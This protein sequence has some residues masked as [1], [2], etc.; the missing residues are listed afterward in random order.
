M[1]L[2]PGIIL[3]STDFTTLSLPIANKGFLGLDSNDNHTKI[4]KNDGSIVDLEETGASINSPTFTGVPS[5]PT[6]SPGT[7][8]TQF[9]TT[10]FVLANIPAGFAIINITY[11]ALKALKDTSSLQEGYYRITDF[12]T[13]YDQP[14]FS[15]PGVIKIPSLLITK[16]SAVESI[17]VLAISSDQLSPYAYSESFPDDI[18]QYDI[19][20]SVTEAKGSPAKGRISY[21]KDDLG[22]TTDYDHRTVLFK[23]YDDG[24][25]NF[26]IYWDNGNASQEFFTFNDPL[27]FNNIIGNFA[28]VVPDLFPPLYVIL[29][30]NIFT[31]QAF[32]N[33]LGDINGS[34]TFGACTNNILGSVC[35]ANI[36]GDSC[37]GNIFR[38]NCS[39]NRLTGNCNVNEFGDA[40]SNNTW[41][42]GNDYNKIGD[43]NT[44]TVYAGDDCQYNI[45]GDSS[46]YVNLGNA[47]RYNKIGNQSQNVY[48]TG[49]GNNYNV[50][51]DFN[52]VQFNDNNLRNIIGSSNANII[53]ADSNIDNIIGDINININ[54]HAGNQRNTFG[55]N[56]DIQYLHDNNIDNKFNSNQAP[57]VS[58]VIIDGLNNNNWES[59]SWNAGVG[60]PFTATHINNSYFCNIQTR[61]DGTSRLVYIDN[62]DI[63]TVVDPAT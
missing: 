40:F 6:A 62:T 39:D 29:S 8:T 12:T 1:T 46:A 18:I 38:S 22:N 59:G 51:G 33:K 53:I 55:N 16:T 14:D 3:Q 5:G 32:N 54:M 17:V 31:G 50:I 4:K 58:F 7:N 42:T 10:A 11:S 57:N 13:I 30:N 23:R 60:N 24:Y 9:A 63:L 2:K 20:Y 43:N 56:N 37:N 47:N 26:I 28:A 61:V 19:T 34:N 44:G 27:S 52:T 15:A 41:G 49:S 48:F 45:V 21:R 25:G 36:L 35:F